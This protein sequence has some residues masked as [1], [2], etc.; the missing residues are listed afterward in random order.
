[1]L[2][3]YFAPGHPKLLTYLILLSS[4]WVLESLF[5]E[6]AGEE[7]RGRT[8]A[9]SGKITRQKAQQEQRQN[10]NLSYDAKSRSLSPLTGCFRMIEIV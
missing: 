4:Q 3:L 9:Q 2:S 1:M 7:P 5:M 10:L 8:D 6:R